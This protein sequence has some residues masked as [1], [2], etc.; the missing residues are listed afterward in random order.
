MTKEQLQAAANATAT[1]L[2]TSGEVFTKSMMGKSLKP[3]ISA[4]IRYIKI[5]NMRLTNLEGG[6]DGK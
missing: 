6:A 4:I 5:T 2:T 1:E 3:L